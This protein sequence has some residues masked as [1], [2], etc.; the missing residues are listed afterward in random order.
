MSCKHLHEAFA[1]HAHA[2]DSLRDA[3]TTVKAT[4]AAYLEVVSPFLIEH[5]SNL[6]VLAVKEDGMSVNDLFVWSTIIGNG[7]LAWLFWPACER[8][9]RMAL[10][11]SFICNK[12]AAQISWG[13][14]EVEQR[15]KVM[16]SWAT[17]VIDSAISQD[18]AFNVL[19]SMADGWGEQTALDLAMHLE[20]KAFL[21]HRHCQSL[22]DRWWRGGFEGS[23]V[24]LEEDTTYAEVIGYAYREVEEVVRTWCGCGRGRRRKKDSDTEDVDT[25]AVFEQAM[26]KAIELSGQEHE[27]A[28]SRRPEG[29][30]GDG[31]GG[32][33]SRGLF[34]GGS[35]GKSGG[36]GRGVG[37]CAPSGAKEKRS[38]EATVVSQALARRA[39]EKRREDL[40][41]AEER[42]SGLFA[43]P[44][45]VYSCHYASH[46]ILVLLYSCV[47]L[48]VP[49]GSQL[50]QMERAPGLSSTEMLFGVWALGHCLDHLHQDRALQGA[51]AAEKHAQT[52]ASFR[53]LLL[54]SDVIL[55]VALLCRLMA[56]LLPWDFPGFGCMSVYQVLLSADVIVIFFRIAMYRFLQSAEFGVLVIIMDEMASDLEHFLELFA[57]LIVGFSFTFIGFGPSGEPYEWEVKFHELEEELL[58]TGA[59]GGVTGDAAGAGSGA[60]M[61]GGVAAPVGQMMRMA[62][63]SLRG[64]GGDGGGGGA[65]PLY[66]AAGQ[67]GYTGMDEGEQ[68]QQ[69]E[70]LPWYSSHA[71]YVMPFWA[72]FGELDLDQIEATMPNG[73]PLAM[74]LYIFLSSIVMVNL[75]VAMFA[76]TYTR[77]KDNSE[78]EYRFQKCLRIFTYRHVAH[79]LPP[80]FN[81]YLVLRNF[82]KAHSE[83]K[84]EVKHKHKHGGQPK[85]A[86]KRV[87]GR[88]RSVSNGGGGPGGGGGA[89]GGD[90][91]D[92]LRKDKDAS[93]ADNKLVRRYMATKASDEAQSLD[94]RVVSLSEAAVSA[95]TR[96]AAEHAEL[97]ALLQGV[98]GRVD[99]IGGRLEKLEGI[100]EEH[101]EKPRLQAEQW[102]K[103]QEEVNATTGGGL[104]VACY[105]SPAS[106]AAI[107][108]KEDERYAEE[109]RRA[110]AAAAAVKAAAPAAVPA[111][112]TP[113]GSPAPAPKPRW[114]QQQ[115]Q[116]QQQQQ[117]PTAAV[118]AAGGATS[119]SVETPKKAAPSP[120][121]RCGK[122][123][124]AAAYEA[125]ISSGGA[126]TSASSSRVDCA[127]S[128]SY[129]G[130]YSTRRD[131]EEYSA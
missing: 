14:H 26:M 48:G 55:L 65:P 27:S 47:L 63:R 73:G 18:A 123:A 33:R 130:A 98:V 22:M 83:V 93:K 11:G 25:Q 101:L 89:G 34:A 102:R 21:S 125:A 116:Q 122:S 42:L 19:G 49:N 88:R 17:G 87:Q 70:F 7:E 109:R 107:K 85:G 108:A 45:V 36:T 50:E 10:L 62:R 94:G 43:V 13:R 1:H 60:A 8:P 16:E 104:Q 30:G 128:R 111:V 79:S 115:Q 121:L 66:A 69:A 44:I 131:P 15:A 29:E 72:L 53:R 24:V 124:A 52:H 129:G 4:H 99:T 57:L 35:G 91:Q 2:Q 75:L 20:M 106:A 71:E 92:P 56:L 103:A 84:R 32:G 81:L 9:V 76:E 97:I 40:E 64:G 100:V 39:S 46:L 118:S 51:A 59:A 113:P 6:V 23:G 78:I 110:S 5:F 54:A 80:P 117:P 82:G 28:G 126:A 112:A 31:K 120:K 127:S 37:V 67:P 74:W 96:R 3:P 95:E 41:T 68:E 90:D 105:R 12:L 86:V 38:G 58:H 119:T 77:V 114:G 61:L